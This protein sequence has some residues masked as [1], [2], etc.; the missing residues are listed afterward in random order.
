MMTRSLCALALSSVALSAETILHY[1]VSDGDAATVAGGTVPGADGSP[2]GVVFSG[3][4]TL[5]E[6]IPSEGV[7]LDA[8]N[9]SLAFDGSAG[10]NLPGTQQLLN[11]EVEAA[12]GFT[13]EAWFAFS[14]GGNI[15][16]IID[17]AGTEKLVREAAGNGAGYRNNSAPPLYAIG[18]AGLDEWHYVAVVFEATELAG[19]SVTGNFTFYFDGTE[20]VEFI[21]GV[22]ISDFGDSLNRTISVGAHPLGFG[23]D[24]YNGLIFEPRVSLAPLQ[25]GELLYGGQTGDLEPTITD[26]ELSGNANQLTWTSIGGQSYE[27]E[28]S[29]DLE[30][31]NPAGTTV[32]EGET[33]VFLHELSPDFEELIG[34]PNLFYRVT[35]QP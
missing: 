30:N 31:W 9:R 13:Y 32:A 6:D 20:P 33:T 14:G 10:I 2:N 18:S 5:S 8:G 34:A 24:F 23:G 1:R 3:V 29:T 27:V 12:G 28:Y 11:S 19:A 35:L 26:L 17:Y 25:P 15:N 16:S 22:T 4:V 7:P 21:E